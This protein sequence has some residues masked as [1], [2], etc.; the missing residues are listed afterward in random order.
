M[1]E[2]RKL[3]LTDAREVCRDVRPEDRTEW[4]TAAEELGL[5]DSLVRLVVGCIQTSVVGGTIVEHDRPVCIWGASEDR[6]GTGTA[7]LIGTNRGQRIA[8]RIQRH[9]KEGIA[10]MHS[11]FPVLEAHAFEQ[12]LLHHYWMERLG[13]VRSGMSPMLTSGRFILFS[14][15]RTA[16]CA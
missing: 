15:D 4:L 2:R 6:P 9:F 5:G 13:F 11:L 8:H 12:N 1:I 14:R 10:E 3:H 16:L 7:W